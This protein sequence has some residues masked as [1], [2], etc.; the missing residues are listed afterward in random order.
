MHELLVKIADPLAAGCRYPEPAGL[1]AEA[2]ATSGG[3][4]RRPS[5]LAD[6]REQQ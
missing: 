4:E 6:S 3:A 1:A 2:D 5:V